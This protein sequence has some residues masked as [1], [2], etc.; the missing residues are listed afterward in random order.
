MTTPEQDQPSATD[1]LKSAKS[2][3]IL[4]ALLL[5]LF[6][7][8]YKFLSSTPEEIY[9]AQLEQR[10]HSVAQ[11]IEK[12]AIPDANLLACIKAAAEKYAK[13]SPGNSGGIDSVRE[14][15]RLHCR[16]KNIQ[17]IVGIEALNQLRSLNLSNNN[18]DD[19][20]P[21]ASSTQLKTLY[22]AGNPLDD[23][24]ALKGLSALTS[25]SL[26]ELNDMDCDKIQVTLKGATKIRLKPCKKSSAPSLPV[27]DKKA[28]DKQAQ[29]EREAQSLSDQEEQALLDYEYDLMRRIE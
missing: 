24:T 21:L 10:R 17:S 16:Q 1:T 14:L 27:A 2:K 6:M 15:K 11:S 9:A 4:G 20:T 18:I 23:I 22:I 7:V 3:I 25:L 13:I 28:R 19:I 5:Y 8:G 26:P 12:L 29:E